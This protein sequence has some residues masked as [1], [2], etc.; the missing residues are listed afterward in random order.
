M[1]IHPQYKYLVEVSPS[2]WREKLT[3]LADDALGDGHGATWV[4]ETPST[5]TEYLSAVEWWLNA[6]WGPDG[7]QSNVGEDGAET[8]Y[9]MEGAEGE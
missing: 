1:R 3:E 2:L 6:Y 5:R 7:P 9:A 4:V 8:I